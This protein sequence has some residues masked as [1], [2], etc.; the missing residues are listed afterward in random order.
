[1]AEVAAKVRTLVTNTVESAQK[2]LHSVEEEAQKAVH[3][4]REQVSKS[5]AEAKKLLDEWLVTVNEALKKGDELRR[6]LLDRVGLAAHD[7]VTVIKAQLEDVKKSLDALHES[8]GEMSKKLKSDLRREVKGIADDVK[9][10][11]QEIGR[12]REE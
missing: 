4:I 2:N 9:K 1:M 11:R 6:D 10:L 3:S 7:E 8:V 12:K 5:Q